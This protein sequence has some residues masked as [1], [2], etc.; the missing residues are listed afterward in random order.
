MIGCIQFASLIIMNTKQGMTAEL[1]EGM[2][3]G[4]Y[5]LAIT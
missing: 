2:K 3:N 5:D 1:V 4:E